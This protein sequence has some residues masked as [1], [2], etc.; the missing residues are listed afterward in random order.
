MLIFAPKFGLR[1][2]PYK[3][4]VYNLLR[5]TFPRKNPNPAY[6]PENTLQP[7]KRQHAAI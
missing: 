2:K 5:K 6:I 3:K 1:A 7:N 4:G